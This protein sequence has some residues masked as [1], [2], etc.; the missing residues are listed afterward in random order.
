MNDLHVRVGVMKKELERL[1][2]DMI[3]FKFNLLILSL[4]LLIT[5]P[6]YSALLHSG[7]LTSHD[8]EGHIIRMFEFD[9]AL[10]D[11]HFPVR[12]SKRLNWGLGY[13]YFNFNYPLTYYLTFVM[14]KLGFDLLTAFKTILLLSFPLSGFFTFL[15]LKQHFSKTAAF[16]GGLFYTLIPYHFVNV[17]VRGNLA[18]TLAL[19]ILPLNFYLINYLNQKPNL[20]RSI[21][22]NFGL[23]SLIL[24]HNLSALLFLP[25]ILIYGLLLSLQKNYLK[26]LFCAFVFPLLVTCFFWLPAAFDKQFITIDQTFPL[27]YL[28]HFP[29]LKDLIYSPWGYGGSKVG[30]GQMSVQIGLLHLVIFACSVVAFI[31]GFKKFT[32][33]KMVVFFF[34]LFFLAFFMMLEVSKPIWD[35]VKP[36]QYLQF[37]WRLL[38]VLALTTSFL[39]SFTMSVILKIIPQKLTLLLLTVVILGLL[40][41]NRNHWKANKYYQLP[42]YWF[43][44]RPYSSTTTVD[45][46]HTPKWQREDRAA[47]TARF[48]LASGVADIKSLKWRTNY[49][50]FQVD[51]KS[52][53]VMLDRTV[54]F[55]GWTVFIDGKKVD[56]FS[57]YDP[58]TKGLIGFWVPEGKHLIEIK[59]LEPDLDKAADMV[60]LLSIILLTGLI[61]SNRNL[62]A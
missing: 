7:M 30:P 59:L 39:A 34:S 5:F 1:S 4:F 46:E 12:W 37:P 33:K 41:V 61:Y 42:D 35:A 38:S 26:F 44:D 27:Y 50:A 23:S 51:A 53:A 22:L 57:P 14:S 20:N 19:T 47:E 11:G 56:T 52:K 49:H 10:A 29:Q 48:D 40:F 21:L 17:Y 25:I 24:T 36:I 62:V 43:Q 13:P 45:G 60:S 15:W 2:F 31:T 8:G 9:N 6:A 16:I 32:Q 58:K 55:P 3:S 54:Y 18:E 28:K